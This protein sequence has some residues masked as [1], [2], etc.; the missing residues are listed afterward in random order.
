MYLKIIIIHLPGSIMMEVIV[1]FKR[2]NFNE[3]RGKDFSFCSGAQSINC[4]FAYA[5]WPGCFIINL[6]HSKVITR[7][8]KFIQADIIA[9]HLIRAFK[10][11]CLVQALSHSRLR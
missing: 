2:K 1:F 5:F 10:K 7:R 3:C 4:S 8:N 6:Y 11:D 9:P